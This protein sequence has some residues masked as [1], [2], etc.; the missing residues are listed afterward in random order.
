M[1]TLGWIL[2]SS[3]MF[4]LASSVDKIDR[5]RNQ[6]NE[7]ESLSVDNKPPMDTLA[8]SAI[9]LKVGNERIKISWEFYDDI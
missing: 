1:A 6:E 7:V 4:V 5:D 8:S 2:S 3:S 9:T